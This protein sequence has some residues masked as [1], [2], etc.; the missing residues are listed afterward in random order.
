MFLSSC[1]LVQNLCQTP[2]LQVSF[3]L[4]IT[5]LIV[6][7]VLLDI[8]FF[9]SF[10]PLLQIKYLHMPSISQMRLVYQLKMGLI[11]FYVMLISSLPHF[12]YLGFIS[13]STR[14]LSFFIVCLQDQNIIKQIN[15]FLFSIIV[16]PFSIIQT[17]SLFTLNLQIL[18]FIVCSIFLAS[19]LTLLKHP[20][21]T[22]FFLFLLINFIPLLSNPLVFFLN[23]L[24][25]EIDQILFFFIPQLDFLI[26]L[27]FILNL[28]FPLDKIF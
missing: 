1:L 25:L 10:L 9:V 2:L 11:P 17:P 23:I 13:I 5:L 16:A 18:L 7:F 28:I 4:T 27:S 15:P 14:L 19:T 3:Q 12:E 26:M 24:F 6:L 21:I 22:L 8:I 20:M